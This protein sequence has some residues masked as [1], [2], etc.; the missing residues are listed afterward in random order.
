M[1]KSC[2][3]LVLKSNENHLQFRKHHFKRFYRVC[4]TVDGIAALYRKTQWFVENGKKM[5]NANV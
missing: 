2:S 4:V 5:F 1:K 3:G